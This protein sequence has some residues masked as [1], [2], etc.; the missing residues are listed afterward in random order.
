MKLFG[1]DFTSVKDTFY[2]E[3]LKRISS[4]II[5]EKFNKNRIVVKFGDEGKKFFLILKGEV[6]VIL[7]TKK[8]AILQQRE[9]KRY[10]LLLY[11]YKEYEILKLVIKDNKL[12]QNQNRMFNASYYFFPDENL[13]TTNLNQNSNNNTNNNNN[14]SNYSNKEEENNDKNNYYYGYK[15]YKFGFNKIEKR[16]SI[17]ILI[18]IFKFLF[19]K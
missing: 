17:S 8:N 6:Q 1:E 5:Y 2:F 19:N 4:T 16:K 11:I 10:L 9:F 15:D 12:N 3:Q 14:T 7:P 18:N 13:N